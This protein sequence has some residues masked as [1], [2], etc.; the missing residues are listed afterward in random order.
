MSRVRSVVEK[1]Q[2]RVRQAAFRRTD[3][4][5]LHVRRMNLRRFGLTPEE[6]D[7]KLAAQDGRCASCGNPDGGRNQW[8]V[9]SHAVDHNHATGDNR[10][11]LCMGCNRALGL[12]GDSAERVRQLFVYRE[13]YA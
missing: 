5:R 10:G 6:Y 3:A 7:E 4:G 1:E 13:S 2:D 12:L 8:G 11:L 9:I